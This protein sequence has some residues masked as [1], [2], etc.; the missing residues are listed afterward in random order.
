MPWYAALNLQIWLRKLFQFH[1]SKI[2]LRHTNSSLSTSAAFTNM[3]SQVGVDNI[4]RRWTARLN[5]LSLQCRRVL[6]ELLCMGGGENYSEALWFRC[7]AAVISY[8]LVSVCP[9]SPARS[10]HWMIHE[11]IIYV[12]REGIAFTAYILIGQVQ[13]ILCSYWSAVC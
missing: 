8:F 3:S 1:S 9:F 6:I 5:I 2:Q 13:V 12:C 10:Q 7:S 4:D 11:H